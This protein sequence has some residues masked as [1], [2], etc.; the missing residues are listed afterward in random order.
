MF[1]LSKFLFFDKIQFFRVSYCDLKVGDYREKTD[2]LRFTLFKSENVVQSKVNAILRSSCRSCP[3]SFMSE[4][5]F[6]KKP[7][8]KISFISGDRAL[9]RYRG[10]HICIV[11]IPP[12]SMSG[13]ERVNYINVCNFS[14]VEIFRSAKTCGI[15]MIRYRP[16]MVYFCDL[17]VLCNIL[18]YLI[19]WGKNYLWIF[20]KNNPSSYM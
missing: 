10:L 2:F 14:K 3:T 18:N 12:P 19:P 1:A 13:D 8:E 16:N 11:E 7:I 17:R 20:L 6:S 5:I 9:E 4:L 15:R